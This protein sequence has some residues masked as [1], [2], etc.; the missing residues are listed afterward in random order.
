M[1]TTDNYKPKHAK[2]LKKKV[3]EMFEG[4]MPKEYEPKHPRVPQQEELFYDYIGTKHKAIL[5]YDEDGDLCITADS[6][7]FD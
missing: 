1:I 3:I 7:V 5:D 4:V 2:S 6:E